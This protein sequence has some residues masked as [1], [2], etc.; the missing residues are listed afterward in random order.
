MIDELKDVMEL[1]TG[2]AA[3]VKSIL[4]LKAINTNKDENEAVI[5]SSGYGAQIGSCGYGAQIGSSGYYAQ[6]GSCGYYA[7]IGSSG[8]YA[9]IGSSGDYAQIGSC[10][11]YA[12]IGS[13]GDSAKIN[14]T[15]KK[16]VIASIGFWTIAKGEIGSW[17][18]LAEYRIDD[19]NN[20]YPFFV[21]TEYID[22]ERIKADTY[23][24]LYDK[25]FREVIEVDGILSLL[26]SGEKNIK[27]VVLKNKIKPSYI[28]IKN[29]ISAHGETVKQAYRDW[30]FKQSDRDVSKYK[31]ISPDEVYSLDFWYECYRNI[32]GACAQGTEHFIEEFKP[33]KEMTLNEVIE[34]TKGQYGHN[35]FVD[36][37]KKV[38]GE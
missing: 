38:K 23:Y 17:I 1:A 19:N 27:K 30:L 11:D 20:Y 28:F 8:D 3:F 24:G 34:I 14:S 36:F 22:G 5:K 29:G 12:K 21:K 31:N 32:T 9:K 37:F 16:A 35:T 6:I 33:K 25:E 18:T 15:G 4:D 2:A 7:Q 10:G 26:I 13:S